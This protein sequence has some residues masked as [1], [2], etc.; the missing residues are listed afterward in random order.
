MKRNVLLPLITALTIGSIHAV[1]ALSEAYSADKAMGYFQAHN[2]NQLIPYLNG[3]TKAAP[4]DAMPWYY[5]GTSYG[6]KSHGIG[7]ER[8]EEAR[9]AFKK[10]VA[11]KPNFP[12][13]WNA[14]GYTEI[15]LENYAGAATAFEHATQQAPSNAGYWNSLGSTYAK[16]N[17]SAQATTA[18][19]KAA[20][21]GSPDAANN[22]RILHTPQVT[23]PIYNAGG[24]AGGNRLRSLTNPYGVDYNYYNR[25]NPVTGSP[26]DH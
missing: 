21:L 12:K 1:P 3:W 23:M 25:L 11:L 9:T 19:K 24:F 22:N 10:C 16:L 26:L 17:R 18:F 13:A 5:L 4:N 14:L 15:E 2:W 6:S 8:P 20:H 7:M